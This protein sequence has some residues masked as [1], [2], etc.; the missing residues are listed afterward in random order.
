MD[1]AYRIFRGEMPESAGP[2]EP[3]GDFF[4]I[5]RKDPDEAAA[6]VRELARW[7]VSVLAEVYKP[8]H[9]TLRR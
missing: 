6:L 2:N 4:V 1:N 5:A 8:A 3:N 9:A 7:R